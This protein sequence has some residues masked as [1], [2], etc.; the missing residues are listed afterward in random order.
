MLVYSLML[1]GLVDFFDVLVGGFFFVF[2]M[3]GI[4][5]KKYFLV[6]GLLFVGVLLVQVLDVGDILF[7]MNSGSSMLSKMIKNSI[8]SG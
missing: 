1:S 4:V 7:F 2:F 8:D 6:F 5:M 3:D